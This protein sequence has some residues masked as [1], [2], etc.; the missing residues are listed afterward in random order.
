MWG[1]STPGTAGGTNA[2]TTT[3]YIDNNYNNRKLNFT[4]NKSNVTI[5]TVD[6]YIPAYQS[7]IG[8]RLSIYNSAGTVIATSSTT[9]T[10]SAGAAAVKITNT[11]NYNIAAAGNYSIGVSNG[12]GNIGADNPTYPITEP[13]G[14]ITI[15][16]GASSGLRCFNNI[17][18]PQT[19][20]ATAH[21][22]ATDVAGSFNY[23]VT[24]TV[25][26][27]TSA[28]AT[29]TVIVTA[30]PA[31]TIS[32]AGN[33]FCKS[34]AGT[35]A[36]SQT[37]TTGGV[38]SAP[39]GLSIN[40]STGTIT[41]GMSTAGVYTVSYTMTGSGGCAN[42]VATTSVTIKAAPDVTINKGETCLGTNTGTISANAAVGIGPYTYSLNGGA[43]QSSGN[44]TGLAAGNYTLNVLGNTGCVTSN[45]VTIT[46]PSTSTDDQSAAGTDSWIG[47]MYDGTN[48]NNY[49]GQFTE[50]E[51]FNENFGGDATCF[52][53]QSAGNYRSV[54]TETFSVK[55]RMNST[56]KGLYVAN[57]GSDD[58]ARLTIDGSMIF[59][60]WVDHSFNTNPNVLMNLG[61]SSNMM[62]EFYEN[63]GSN[64]VIFQNFTRLIGNTLTNNTNQSVCIGNSAA[65]I[66]GDV[67]A[68][69]PSGISLSGTGYQW[70]YST[71]PGGA[72]TNI[73][74][75]TAA[76]FTP[77]TASAPFNTA[78]TYYVY[79]IAKLSSANNIS[80]VPYVASN[81]SNAAVI[82]VSG[83]GQW[84]G[85]V[86]TD[87][88]N[89]AN[90]CT[91]IAPTSATDVT[92][93]SGAVRMPEVI[94]TGSCRSLIIE[95]GASVTTMLAG[96]LNVAGNITSNGTMTNNGTTN[97]NGTSSQTFSGTNTFYNVTINNAAGVVL[98]YN[99]VINNNLVIASG[100]FNTNNYSIGIKGNWTNNASATAFT[101]GTGAVS[102]MGTAPQVIGGGFATKFNNLFISSTTSTVLLNVNAVV[103]G[104][105]TVSTGTF[106]LT[107]FTANRET[108]GGTLTVA[109]DAFL[110]IGGTNTFPT[111]FTTNN[112][113]VA[114]T[115]EYYGTDQA[116]ANQSYGNLVLSSASG[117]VVKTLPATAMTVVGNFTSTKGPGTSVT[118]TAGASITVNG[119]VTIG[120][121]TTFNGSGFSQTMG[122]NW[123]NNG[124]FNGNT[125]TVIFTGTGATIGGTGAQNFN[126]LTVSASLI[127]FSN[128]AVSLTGNLATTG[129]GSFNLSSGGTLTMTG[130]SKTIS[131]FGISIDNLVI[132]G[133]V[134]TSSSLT[135]TGNI[136]I[137]GSFV[138]SGASVITMSGAAKTITGAGAKSFASLYVTGSVTTNTD[139]FITSALNI[140]GTFAASAGQATFTN[141]STLTGTASLFNVRLDGTSLKLSSGAVL[142]IASA[143]TI[144]SGIL[145]VTSSTPNTVNFNG[146]G[147]QN[148]NAITYNNLVLSNGNTKSAIAGLTV[149]NDITIAASTTFAAGNFTHSIY[150]NW[151]NNGN[152]TAS[153]GTVQFL[154]SQNTDVY[155][156]TTFNILTVNNTNASTA[157]H[158]HA[159]VSASIVNMVS[160]TMLT[161]ANTITIT[162]TR[163]GN[164]IILGHI[165]R[166]HVFTTGVA[167]AFEGPDNTVEFSAVSGVGSV[168]VYVYKGSIIDFPYNAS[169]SRTYD[170]TISSGTYSA[171]LRLHYEDAELNGNNESSLVL[172]NYNG[173]Y[174]LPFGKS[175][176][177]A[178]A[179]Y[180][181]QTGLMNL[182]N[183]WTCGYEANVAEWNGSISSDWSVPNNWTVL[184]GSPSRPPSVNDVAVIGYS[185]FN[186]Q[187]TISTAVN[188]KNIVFGSA[189]P[190]TL[191]MASGGSLN[192]GDIVGI[193][194]AGNAT[195]TIN[196]NNQ[197]V[198]I[199]GN[200]ALSDG[201]TSRAIN[202]NIGNGNLNII[203]SL[204]QFGGA[205]V[206]FSGAGNLAIRDNYQY[207]NGTFTAGTGTVTYNGSVN[208]IVAPVSYYNL[209]I[210][211]TTSSAFINDSTY[212]AGN[213]TI[214]AG[215]LET[216]ASTHIMGDVSIMPGASFENF[217]RLRV[218]GNWNNSG[219]YTSSAV[220]TNVIFN[221]TG[222]QNISA[223]T[224]HDL[225]INKPVGSVATLT[226]DVTLKGDLIGTSGTLDIKSFFFNRD[227][228]GGSARISD[229]GTLII[230]AN[231]APNKFS[232][233]TLGSA[234]TVIFNGT[235]TQHLLLPGLVYG[236]LIFRNTGNKVLYTP[237]AV[238]GNLTIESGATF[239]G[240]SNTI[241]LNGNW[242][243]SGTY[244]PSTS[245]LMCA[246]NL[247]TISGNNTFHRL[248]VSGSYTML[249]NNTINDLLRITSTGN[250]NGG[251]SIVTT[252]NG[253][254]INNGILYTLGTTTFT[255]NVQQTLSLI[256]AVQ[257]VAITVNFNGTVSP[258][259]NSTSAPQYGFLNINN[260]G[261]VNASV[262][263]NILYGLSVGA[264]AS[265]NAGG[266]THNLY[267][268][269]NN[270]GTIT[271]SGTFNILPAAT[272]TIN[273]GSNFT[274][275]G[276]VVFGGAGA[277]TVN[278]TPASL[279]NVTV[280]NTNVAGVTTTSGWTLTNTLTVNDGSILNAGAGHFNIAGNIENLG[281]INSGTST[282]RLNGT[283]PQTIQSGSSFY[284]MV[285]ENTTSS[286]GL[287]SDVTVD[288]ELN[289]I[290]GNIE[291]GNYKLIQT[292]AGI[293]VNASQTTGWVNGSLQKT[294]APAT[295]LRLF[296]VGDAVNYTPVTLTLQNVTNGGNLL[297]RSIAGDHPH[298]VT[299]RINASK[300]INRYW[301]FVNNGIVFASCD[302]AFKHP[303]SDVDAGAVTSTFGG[304]LYDDTSWAILNA[305]GS[306]DTITTVTTTILT[307]EIAVGEICNKNTSIAYNTTHYCTSAAPVNATVTGNG[308]GV[309]SSTPGLTLNASTGTI[310]P[311]TSTA[312]EYKIV[313]T[314]AAT[315]ECS[316]FTTATT[317]YIDQAPSASIAYGSGP[318]C[319]GGGIIYPTFTGTTGG[320]FSANN[321]LYIDP[322]TGRIDL[323]ANVPGE[324]TVTYSI[325]ASGGCG[326]AGYTAPVSIV[327]A[328]KWMGTADSK[329]FNA[330]N[331][332]CGII[333]GNNASVSFD[334]GS[335]HYPLIDSG[336]V[337]LNNLTVANGASIRVVNAT[338]KIAGVV[339]NAGS[340][341]VSEGILEFAGTQPQTVGLNTFYHNAVKDLIINNSS[342]S[343]LV[344]AGPLDV[345]EALTFSASGKNFTTND[346]LTLKS[347]STGTARVGNMT[348][349]KMTGNVTVEKYIPAHKAWNFLSVPTNSSQNINSS[350]QEGAVNQSSNPLPGFGTQI[351]SNRATWLA[352]GFDAQ[353]AGPSMKRYDQATNNW[354][355]TTNTNV[356]GI[357]NTEG[358]M[359]FIRGDRTV[360]PNNTNAT[361]TV[362]RTKGV[363][364][365]GNLAP[366]AVAARKFVSVGNPYAAPLDMRKI[367]K[368]GVK[369]FFYV[370]DPALGGNYGAGGYQV[371]SSDS[372]G[373][374]VVTPG[375]GSYGPA[376]SVSNYIPSG[377][378]FFVEGDN[379]GGFINFNEHAKFDPL[380]A[381]IQQQGRVQMLV[382]LTSL[383]TDSSILINDGLMVNFNNNFSNAVDNGDAFKSSNTAENISVLTA[384][385]SLIIERR[386]LPASKD[387]IYLKIANMKAKDYRFMINC[388]QLDAGGRF[389]ILIDN[390]TNTSK[391]LQLSGNTEVSFTVTSA[392]ASYASNRFKIVFSSFTVL[393]V[394]FVSLKAYAAGN[395]TVNIDWKSAEEINTNHYEVE[396]SH[397]GT[398][399]SKIAA[400]ASKG[401][402]SNDYTLNDA[403]PFTDINYYRIKGVENSG[404]KVYSNIV[405]VSLG[406]KESMLNVYPN[407][408]T[409]GVTSLQLNNMPKG[410]YQVQLVNISGQVVYSNN[411]NNN[412]RS[413]SYTID[414]GKTIAAGLYQLVTIDPD[415]VKHSKELLVK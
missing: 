315:G 366:I 131:G 5:S 392:A 208:Q 15:T 394:K 18:F 293:I 70:V 88:A 188:V 39:A 303:F 46:A 222:S 157:I 125:G 26:A 296:Q 91:G 363:L 217:S 83:G 154:G 261:G 150:G 342:D 210:N 283:A 338:L 297:V 361:P 286:V 336:V 97:F 117:A 224:F 180:V 397:D 236:N 42:Q 223:T 354:I 295:T 349:V 284:N 351:T 310:T 13:T 166:T 249:N 161:G 406:N 308:G 2:L 130:T 198:N 56:K 25:G 374:Y 242:I 334:A 24:Q 367:S 325:E 113:V 311:A 9:T 17:K 396:R 71:S 360:N 174:W 186:N 181:E 247:K 399:F 144:S 193:W 216:S 253:D 82:V 337:T 205:N 379:T 226:G 332:M 118:Y 407:P 411:F 327:A 324:Y 183:R 267:G 312:G 142:G 326:A 40:S 123:I 137:T 403:S 49:I 101:N 345:Y 96:T 133:S 218:G 373:N 319:A 323:A 196:V 339:N 100:I 413:I 237:I 309:F 128:N 371:F 409:D 65:A 179:N 212:I 29:I 376:G 388:S 129:S 55:F 67:F 77:S 282:F 162:N 352:D 35:V 294:I 382:N 318:Y 357:K 95:S 380:D 412:S 346:F 68:S 189:K 107:T 383:N 58:G 408:V 389:A 141:T 7:V 246:G 32:Y 171:A 314:V 280:S 298:L 362:L 241:T 62:Y 85:S 120:A 251:S 244:V 344:L 76:T 60:N 414:F 299:S 165:T 240:G 290:K 201:N 277:M 187:P 86:S 81:E 320:I 103:Q 234:S 149:N 258:V 279:R 43:Y 80:Y 152:F 61:G 402:N 248:T 197:T 111:N 41:P 89:G 343:G 288:H 102:F 257:T 145:D 132:S 231:N 313:Y 73:S 291:T 304:S 404:E 192:T 84:I 254:L 143:M 191:S 410:N 348:G 126:N 245:T 340:V 316:E 250:I 16:G 358:Y 301:K 31:A 232:N 306:N 50:A 178:T 182:N 112:L 127:T 122:A 23:T 375:G 264:G 172:W 206:T 155:G 300:N 275:T 124:T 194:N 74:G 390:F 199:E 21:T 185:T 14:T 260:T 34:Q 47:H 176:N 148:I 121:S 347:N 22:P 27:C 115:V 330:A 190:V 262:G 219:T 259:L 228:V 99:I 106:D 225:E 285:M 173:T 105:L 239:D 271:S 69:L 256:N 78:G 90:W 322:A 12:I 110:K 153:T 292:A 203:G 307:G 30:A 10:Q 333:P 265:F 230:A 220:G 252:M 202:L 369:D 274:S 54:Y 213:L 398:N 134:T 136:N 384:T 57:L 356:S 44:F 79:R 386:A 405:K 227:N 272:T 3:T 64:Q 243:N 8:L 92:I 372:T 1:S 66:S 51:T 395:N 329:W 229:N 255:G 175:A 235:S 209:A 36:V 52:S 108:L 370:W 281:T 391:P 104:N 28:P 270:N 204:W 400:I 98:P 381:D 33:P 200:L 273:L 350:W 168:S 378:A 387:T 207:I 335:A 138:S 415:G 93:K 317:I 147:A 53:V 156:A 305:T 163:T 94:T 377:L 139:F 331:W 289:F 233:Y 355:M 353:T 164:G 238:N 266:S 158:L 177:S 393:P 278:G 263:Y 45:V 276:R 72:R 159:N 140:S 365:S 359:L 167:Y 20:S 302:A 364:Y 151:Y 75:A 328:G 401:G 321:G 184:Q 109:N 146:T 119:N 87:W 6:Y 116:V 287:L 214:T 37:G 135:I 4:T 63:A 268:Y 195:H 341:D 48:F 269:L 19:A 160:G 170:I 368:T 215:E 169:V 385:K 221:G 114:S 38:Y 211:K 59:N 11:F